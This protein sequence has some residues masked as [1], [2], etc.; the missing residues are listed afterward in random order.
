MKQA[1]IILDKMRVQLSPDKFKLDN[2]KILL[3]V[4]AAIVIAY[5]DFVSLIKVQL[6]GIKVVSPK[7]A[8]LKE[9]INSFNRELAASKQIKQEKQEGV[10][11]AKVIISDQQIPS[12][13][14]EI[15]RLAN[16][17][18]VKILQIR[19]SKELKAKDDKAVPAAEAAPVSIILDVICGYHNF[20]LFLNELENS[21]YFIAAEEM[22]MIP[23]SE[24][25]FMQKVSLTLKT[26]VKK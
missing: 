20:G 21:K 17:N 19:P 11:K 2:K 10:L 15:S 16:K 18:Q 13:L 12:L 26:Y 4:L 1:N 6:E 8:R 7:I 9:D 5:I 23:Q 22:K 24:D 3:I 14:Q 25:Y